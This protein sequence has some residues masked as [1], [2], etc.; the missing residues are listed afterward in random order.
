MSITEEIPKSKLPL[1]YRTNVNGTPEDVTLPFRLLIMGDLSNG[2]SKDRSVD[3]DVR[4]IRQLDGKNL[5]QLMADMKMS[6]KVSVPNRIDPDKSESLDVT[7]PIEGMKS[8]TPAEIAEQ[9]PKVK[10]LLLLRKLLQ[11]LQHNIDNREVFRTLLRQLAESPESVAALREELT[12]FD[13]LNQ[14]EKRFDKQSIQRLI[15]DIDKLVEAQ[16][17]EI[18]HTEELQKMEATWTSIQDLARNTNFKAN[19][20]LSLLD[21]EKKEAYEDLE[22]NLADIAGSELFKKIYAAEYDE[23]G[24]F[25]YG[26]IIGMYEFENTP[27]DISWLQGIGKIAS[28]SHAPFIGNASPKLFGCDTMGEVNRLSDLEGLFSTPQYSAWNAFRDSEEAGYIGLT[29]PRYMARIPY[30]DTT[31]PADGINFTENVRGDDPSSF[32]WA[33]ASML[34]ARTLVRSFEQSGWCQHIRGMKGGGRVSDLPSYGYNIGGKDEFRAP[35]EISMPDYRE[36]ELANLGFIPLVH[37]RGTTEA[38][39]FSAQAAQ[40]THRL[41]DPKDSESSLLAA[42]LSYTFSVSRIAHYV[43]CIMRDNI[44]STV[45]ADYISGQIGGW[46]SRFVTRVATPDDVT[47]S[48]YPFK[49]YDIEVTPVEGEIGRYRCK[50]SVWPHIQFDGMDV[51]FK[52]DTLLSS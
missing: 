22:R 35:T 6:V 33:P 13:D 32:L 37:K 12:G 47:L 44:G 3:L 1:T 7:L 30:N 36:Y 43:K 48:Y 26:G 51:P 17:S 4:S 16:I 38:V 8:F 14:A 10:S 41:M 24:G 23:L 2:T 46:I 11:E 20:Q 19:I 21:I 45:N 25:P 40:L 42:N 50:L 15:A 49:A 27:T 5:N 52:V 29:M 31:N 18:L 9:V 39:F 34:R 28:A